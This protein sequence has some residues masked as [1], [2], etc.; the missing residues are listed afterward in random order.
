VDPPATRQARRALGL[1]PAP[2]PVRS[3]TARAINAV[4]WSYFAGFIFLVAQVGYTALTARLVSPAAYGGY[5]LA[6]TVVQLACLVGM[7]GLGDSVMRVPELTDRGARTALTLGLGS[8]A[9]LSVALIVLSAP[10]EYWFRTPATGQMLRIL[11]VQPPMLAAAA[12]SYGLLRRGQRYQAASLIDLTSSLIGFVVGLAT[13]SRLGAVGLAVGQVARGAVAM[14]VGLVWARVSLRPAFDRPTAREFVAFSAQVASQNLGHYAIGN[15]PLWSVARLA[16]GAAT[17]LFARGY[18]LVSLPAEQFSFGLMRAVYPLYR[19]VSGSRD[20]TRR[21]LTEALV[22][23]SGASAVVFGTF[24]AV[25][26]PAALILLGARWYASA[27]ITPMLCAFAAVNTLYAVLASAAEAMRWMWKIWITQIAFLVAMAVS[28]FLASGELEATAAAMVIATAVAHLFMMLWVS[29]DGLMRTREVLRA[30][31]A[32]T[33]VFVTFA[34]IPPLVSETVTDQSLMVTLAVRTAV[35]VVLAFPVWL[36]RRRIPGLRLGLVRLNDLRSQHVL[37]GSGALRK[38]AGPVSR[39]ARQAAPPWGRVLVN[40]VKLPVS[41]C[42]RAVGLRRRPA[43]GSRRWQAAPPWG[44]VLVNTVKLPVSRRLRAVSLRRRPASGS[45]RWHARRRWRFAAL[46]LALATAAVTVL[47]LTG[48]LTST[49]SRAAPVTPPGAGPPSVAARAQ[50]QAAAW[51]AGQVSGDAIVACDPGMC[52]AL[53]EQGVAAGRLMPLRSAAASPRGASVLVTFPPAS[54]LLAGRYAPALIASFGSGGNRVEVRAVEPGGASAYRAA[55]R[56]DL[57]GRRAAGSQLLQNS[58]IRF[59]GPGAA[60]LRAGEVDTRVLATLAVLASH[61]SFSVAG[62][63]DTGPGAPVLFRQVVI[64]GVGRGLP[65]ALAMVRTQN[66]PYLPARAAVVGRT[67]L[68]I[69]FA[70]P[71]PLGLLSPVLDADS[72]R[73]AAGGGFL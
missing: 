23:T 70:A 13:I 19:E 2:V 8:G 28:L 64:T 38:P 1:H 53:R 57:A 51:I 36:L 39:P 48:G 17:G 15:L 45:R 61:Y 69:E 33:V 72:P 44:R 66:P 41:R 18:A 14:L 67:G 27:A 42:L 26:Q 4:G 68:S 63:A 3:L 34:V 47:W 46:V 21:A 65:A 6:L 56:A 73:P 11:A 40:T 12:V 20:R 32:H 35:F 5:A 59:A 30:Y 71:S 10:I 25:V 29:R 31:A 62:F 58:H 43:S 7:V 55:L 49:P 52:A 22:I 37:P 16:G 9:L 60:Q 24:A 50:A 54:G